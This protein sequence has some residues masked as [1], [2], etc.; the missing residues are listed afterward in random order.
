MSGDKNRWT[1]IYYD[2][3][4][5]NHSIVIDSHSTSPEDS[6]VAT[7]PAQRLFIP[8]KFA[9]NTSSTSVVAED[10]NVRASLDGWLLEVF[11]NDQFALSTR[12]Y[13]SR[14]DS[15]GY[16]TWCDGGCPD[17]ENCG[18]YFLFHS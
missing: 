10:I 14:E 13:P 8:Y 1:T 11:M 7:D 12:I 9:D 17:S 4:P 2:P 3:R 6:L 5:S 15:I 16:G 18:L